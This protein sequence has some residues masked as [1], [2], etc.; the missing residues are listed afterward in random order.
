[1]EY[2]NKFENENEGERDCEWLIE[3]FQ[4]YDDGFEVTKRGLDATPMVVKKF[5]LAP[6]EVMAFT[7]YQYAN[8]ALTAFHF[9]PDFPDEDRRAYMQGHEEG[10]ELV[11]STGSRRAAQRAQFRRVMEG[12]LSGW[13]RGLAVSLHTTALYLAAGGPAAR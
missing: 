12:R 11:L 1:M 6:N 5:D 4:A 9:H 7:S 13:G 2:E 10:H 3:F 8:K